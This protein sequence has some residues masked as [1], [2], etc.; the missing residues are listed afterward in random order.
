MVDRSE[1]RTPSPNDD[2]ALVRRILRGDR[3]E[4]PALAERLRCVPRTLQLL[5][6]RSG[7]LFGPEGLADLTQDVLVL[8]WRKL[9]EFEGLSTLEG[10]T[11]GIC[12]LEFQNALRRGKRRRLEARAIASHTGFVDTAAHDPDPWAFEEVH[13]GL[14][15]IGREEAEVIR[16]KH[17]EGQTFEEISRHLGLSPNTVKTRYYRGL[18]ELRPLLTAR[19]EAKGG[20]G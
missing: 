1:P 9:P 3:A 17:F 11:Y 2:L 10:W 14:R 4:L 7:R 8:T 20:R 13:E 12:V 15:K 18:E 19:E 16:L 5:D 6:R